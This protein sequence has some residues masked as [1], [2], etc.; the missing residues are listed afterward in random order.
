[1]RTCSESSPIP[2]GLPEG[3]RATSP[4]DGSE[5]SSSCCQLTV[6][7]SSER[8]D[9]TWKIST[10]KSTGTTATPATVAQSFVRSG[11][12]RTSAAR[13]AGSASS[14]ESASRTGRAT[15]LDVYMRKLPATKPAATPETTTSAL[16]KAPHIAQRSVI[17]SETISTGTSQPQ[18]PSPR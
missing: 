12:R 13:A 15:R 14:K 2:P 10:A 8:D 17:T 7:R 3:S 9:I 6:N 16:S 5:A 18:K 1:M 11:S 4:C